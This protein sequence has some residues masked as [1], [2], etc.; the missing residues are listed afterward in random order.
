MN[1]KGSARRQGSD[2]RKYAAGWERIWARVRAD[3]ERGRELERKAGRAMARQAAQ[4]AKSEAGRQ[5]SPVKV[6]PAVRC[7]LPNCAIS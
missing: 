1:G 7:S 2:A 3:Q 5:S 4:R 6:L